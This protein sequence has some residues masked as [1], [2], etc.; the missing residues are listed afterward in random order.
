MES[1]AAPLRGLH[2]EAAWFTRARE[3]RLL[4]VQAAP[5]LRAVAL[6]LLM[7]QEYH[8][9]NASFW[10]RL[11]EPH[12]ARD[13][14]W[15]ARAGSLKKQFEEKAAAVAAAPLSWPI[16]GDVA[17]ERQFVSVLAHA[18][19]SVPPPL[20]G[21]VLVLAPGDVEA[22][23]AFAA[24]V[25]VLM[26]APA[27]ARARWV[28]LDA[29]GGP[30][31]RYVGRLPAI[32]RSHQCLLDPAQ[33]NRDLAALAAPPTSTA[34]AGAGPAVSPPPRRRT[35][36][37]PDP[38]ALRAAGISPGY[39]NGGGAE[40]KRLV[41]GAALAL[42]EG[43]PFEAVARQ[44]EAARLC[45]TLEMPR[46]RAINLMVLGGYV[47]AAGSPPQARESYARAA[48][49]ASEAGLPEH[50]AQA[51][52]AL[53]VLEALEQRP[54]E[55]AAHYGTAGRL[56][57]EAA[58]PVLAIECWRM[59]GQLA[60]DVGAE[61]KAVECWRR[62]LSLAAPMPPRI[63]RLTTAAATARALAAAL[64]ERGLTRQADSL[65]VQGRALAPGEG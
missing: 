65:E 45:E 11:D 50:A 32:A 1:L 51:H 3:L 2:S 37:P 33:E 59:A 54:A 61:G 36:G 35:P 22:P 55:A 63:A 7:A 56:A 26:R 64:R 30:I 15:G 57:E 19:R 60:L 44:A 62:A 47:L 12:L 29:S 21:V 49:V 27:L 34:S 24:E 46:E 20:S 23:R 5:A 40:L 10:I 31:P 52:L 58:A 41:L 13:P 28:V 6:R 18:L 53:G 9:D 17:P 4:W 48:A 14:G 39:V 25:A 8:A 43:Q 38:E 16:A 42:R